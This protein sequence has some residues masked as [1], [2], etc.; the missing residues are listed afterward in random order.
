M[1]A[2]GSRGPVERDMDPV[3]PP[4]GSGSTPQPDPE[5]YVPR[6]RVEYIEPEPKPEDDEENMEGMPTKVII[7]ITDE[8]NLR[9]SVIS[10]LPNG[11]YARTE[12]AESPGS[13]PGSPQVVVMHPDEIFAAGTYNPI[14]APDGN[15]PRLTYISDLQAHRRAHTQPRMPILENGIVKRRNDIMRDNDPSSQSTEVVE[16][17]RGQTDSPLTLRP[18][19]MREEAE[20]EFHLQQSLAQPRV[21]GNGNGMVYLA[22]GEDRRHSGRSRNSSV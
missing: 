9:R 12:N 22:Q 3:S 15:N 17:H 8:D 14:L 5:P 1:G 7:R 6:N 21:S 13:G 4:A 11:A 19:D 2:C 20:D 18:Y 10:Q 16:F